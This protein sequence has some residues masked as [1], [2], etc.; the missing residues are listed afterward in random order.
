MAE[1]RGR[2]QRRHVREKVGHGLHHRGLNH[3]HD[4]TGPR[5]RPSSRSL[6]VTYPR[7]PSATPASSSSWLRRSRASQIE[8]L[9]AF[10]ANSRHH[11]PFR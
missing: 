6:T 9:A 8:R 7:A 5:R 3:R 2:A 1:A 4:F 11:T 10:S